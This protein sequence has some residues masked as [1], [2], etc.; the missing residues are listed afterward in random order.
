[1]AAGA[2]ALRNGF[3][4]LGGAFRLFSL[5]LRQKFDV[6]ETFTHH[7]NLIGCLLGWTAGVPVRIASHHGRI[8]GLPGW[9]NRLHTWMLNRGI[10]QKMVV[11]SRQVLEQAVEDGIQPGRLVIIPNGV[12]DAVNNPQHADALRADLLPAP[13]GQVLLAVGRLVAPKA[14]TFLLNALPGVLEQ[15]PQT[16][17]VLA[18]DGPL[19]GELEAEALQLGIASRIRFLGVRAD[20]TD[21]MAA[22]DL[23]ALPSRSEGMPLALLEAMRAGLPI[24]ATDVPGVREALADGQCGLIVPAEDPAALARALLRFLDDPAFAQ[25]CGQSARVRF[26][27]EF[28]LQ[29][30]MQRYLVLL[31]P[32]AARRTG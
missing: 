23:F 26:E 32:A 8:E 22:A 27:Q 15:H 28:T 21:L 18:G 1:R 14:H 20:V 3:L 30:M 5:L 2:G 31:D 25:Q 19:R 10:A 29:K 9:A 17:V 16:A 7:S 4:F 11:V 6:I 24:I 13:T 12:P